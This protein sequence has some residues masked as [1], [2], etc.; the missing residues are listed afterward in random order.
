MTFRPAFPR[1]ARLRPRAGGVATAFFLL[2]LAVSAAAATV[3]GPM[4]EPASAEAA[5][6]HPTLQLSQHVDVP[7][8][9]AAVAAFSDAR[10]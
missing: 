4:V 10:R 5:R 9:G 1:S 8:P 7:P 3:M 2:A 6:P